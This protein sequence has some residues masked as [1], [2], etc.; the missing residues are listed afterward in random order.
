MPTASNPGED[1]GQARDGE[2]GR[3]G[4]RRRAELRHVL[5]SL[6]VARRQVPSAER[7]ADP[8]RDLHVGHLDAGHLAVVHDDEHARRRRRRPPAGRQREA[9]RREDR[10]DGGH[11]ARGTRLDAG[12]HRVHGHLVDVQHVHVVVRVDVV[13]GVVG[14]RRAPREELLADRDVHRRAAEAHRGLAQ[15]E[16]AP[17]AIG[18]GDLEVHP[19]RVAV[20]V[21]PELADQLRADPGGELAA[22][23]EAENPLLAV[24]PVVGRGILEVRVALEEDLALDAQR[25]QRARLALGRRHGLLRERAS[26]RQEQPQHDAHAQTR[27]GPPHSARSGSSRDVR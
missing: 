24:E 1:G 3:R 11:Q 20:R 4:D 18:V 23:L 26:G 27:S 25:G 15:A 19:V 8:G 13:G 7:R 22:P 9:A 16:D 6:V 21:A 10:H 17:V 12:R 14:V 5:E 2:A